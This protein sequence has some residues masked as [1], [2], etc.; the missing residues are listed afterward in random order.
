LDVT[1]SCSTLSSSLNLAHK[2]FNQLPRIQIELVGLKRHKLKL[3]ESVDV[4]TSMCMHW[5]EQELAENGGERKG[6]VSALCE[7]LN[8]LYINEM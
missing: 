3:P 2:E 1:K 4:L 7:S 5:L 8:M 6:E